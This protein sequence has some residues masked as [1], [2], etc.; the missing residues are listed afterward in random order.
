MST[1]FNDSIISRRKICFCKHALTDTEV[2][3]ERVKSFA[4]LRDKVFS[5]ICSFAAM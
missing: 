3:D 4:F 1:W 5:R 2:A